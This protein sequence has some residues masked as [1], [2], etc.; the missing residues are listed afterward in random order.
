MRERLFLLFGATLVGSIA[1]NVVL[2]VALRSQ[3]ID[4]KIQATQPSLG[5]YADANQ[6][7]QTDRSAA[8]A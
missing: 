3:Y 4:S 1:L 7:L 8:G 2:A 6:S 5:A